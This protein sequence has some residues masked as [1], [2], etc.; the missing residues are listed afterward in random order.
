MGRRIPSLL[1]HLTTS[2]RFEATYQELER[3]LTSNIAY[4]RKMIS[5]GAF[6]TYFDER[7]FENVGR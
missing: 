1:S 6:M 4:S 5:S 2:G 3:P 7:V